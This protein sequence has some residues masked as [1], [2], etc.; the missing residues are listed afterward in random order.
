MGSLPRP[1]RRDVYSGYYAKCRFVIHAQDGDVAVL[2]TSDLS[3]VDTDWCVPVLME[4]ISKI[5]TEMV[6]ARR[7]TVDD[8]LQSA[9][10]FERLVLDSEFIDGYIGGRASDPC[11]QPWSHVVNSVMFELCEVAAPAVVS[12]PAPQKE[13]APATVVIERLADRAAV[14]VETSKATRT[15]L[16]RYAS[17]VESDPELREALTRLLEASRI[18]LLDPEGGA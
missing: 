6:S 15:I 3:V 16:A 10:V 13:K 14:L 17:D 7:Y 5:C 4:A 1:V 9:A 8:V 18:E 2:A 11:W 12:L